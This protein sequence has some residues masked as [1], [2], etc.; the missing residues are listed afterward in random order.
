MLFRSNQIAAQN[1]TSPEQV[2]GAVSQPMNQLSPEIL[3]QMMN[4]Q[5]ANPMAMMA[6]SNGGY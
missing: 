6:G 1:G 4:V 3:G 5:G 2:A